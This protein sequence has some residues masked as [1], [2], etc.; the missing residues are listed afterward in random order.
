[1]TKLVCRVLDADGR[2]LGWCAHDASVRGDGF[3]RASRDVAVVITHAGTPSEMSIHWADVNVETRVPMP[4]M[5]VQAGHAYTVF[6]ANAPMLQ[7]G[8]PPVQRLPP[9]T[10][11][12]TYV[13]VPVGQLG[14]SGVL[15]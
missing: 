10:V 15:A 8:Q 1:M 6:Q 2:L 14:A 13:A 4:P 11:D 9:V 12:G 5:A 7:A 3:L